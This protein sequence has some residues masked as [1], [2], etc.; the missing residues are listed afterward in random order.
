MGYKYTLRQ[1]II[2]DSITGRVEKVRAKSR[3]SLEK[4]LSERM[5]I[6]G[7]VK[8]LTKSR[9]SREELEK[10]LDVASRWKLPLKFLNL[11]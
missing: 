5:T 11:P 4:R 6:M 10:R 9:R 2:E 1:W 3:R 7:T 8:S